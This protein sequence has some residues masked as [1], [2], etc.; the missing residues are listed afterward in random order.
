MTDTLILLPILL[1]SVIIHEIAHGAMALRAGDPTA[2]LSGRLTLNPIPH[3]DLVGSIIV[4]L[5]SLLTAG[6]VFIAWA[7]P[8]PVNPLNFRRPRFDEL[9]VAAAGPISNLILA[10]L[11]GV[12]AAGLVLFA[13]VLGINGGLGEELLRFL[14]QMFYLGITLNIVLAVFN[15][16]PVPPLDGSHVIGAFLPLEAAEA[17]AR[18]G[19]WGV[20]IILFLMN[21]PAFYTAFM[22]IVALLRAPIMLFLRIVTQA[23]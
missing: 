14:V 22:T 20:F 12:I 2:K 3:I 6:Q 21:V 8:V 7:K 1:F 23:I 4:P 10:A 18:I 15:L 16:I 17:Y 9:L 13:G 19:F 5:V 11:C